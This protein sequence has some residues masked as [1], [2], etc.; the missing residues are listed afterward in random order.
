MVV[1]TLTE[2]LL[3]TVIEP[4]ED[5]HLAI[6]FY[7]YTIIVPLVYIWIGLKR[8][9]YVFFRAGI[10]LEITGILA[11]KYYHSIM[12]PETA[13]MLGGIV[14]IVIAYFSIKYLKTPKHGIT[15]EIY[16][17]SNKE[18]ALANIASIVASKLVATQPLPQRD[19]SMEPGGGQFGGGG[20]GADY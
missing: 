20:A 1:R 9:E 15:F 3:N 7:A 19:S 8:K 6:L 13:M 10:L 4:G 5:I 2:A 14:V 12:P 11:I 18:E 16:K 17:R